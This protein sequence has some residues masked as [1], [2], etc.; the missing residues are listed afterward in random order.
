M[1]L[2]GR[3]ATPSTP[4]LDPPMLRAKVAKNRMK[5]FKASCLCH[6]R[7]LLDS[8]HEPLVSQGC[9]KFLIDC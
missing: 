3:V 8:L 9:D 2:K 7:G 1:L 6:W 4:P 5:S